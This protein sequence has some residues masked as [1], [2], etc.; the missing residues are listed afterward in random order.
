MEIWTAFLV[1]LAGSLHCIGMC[2]PIALALP[3]GNHSQTGLV[4]NRLLYNLGRV[5]TYSLFGLVFGIFGQG[6]AVAG[7]QRIATIS[8]GVIIILWFVTPGKYKTTITNSGISRSISKVFNKLFG[9]FL[10]NPSHSSLF[11]LGILNGFLPCGFV[12]VGVAGAI[13]TGGVSSSVLYMI[14]FGLGTV[15]SMFAVSFAGKFINLE[16]RRKFNRL[17]PV[18]A[19]VL[20]IIFIFRGLNLGIPFL[21]PK[22]DGKTHQHMMNM[23]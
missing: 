18:F 8:L 16:L 5:L 17:I 14:L 2:G 11:I 6:L 19:M 12:Y 22:L 21:S 13:S 4:L 1:G 7:L 15:P 20:A 10:Q 23:P 9:K 3:V